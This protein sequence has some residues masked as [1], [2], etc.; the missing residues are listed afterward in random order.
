MCIRDSVRARVDGGVALLEL[1]AVHVVGALVA[2]V[3]GGDDEL[4]PGLLERRDA[5][6]Y[7]R[8]LARCV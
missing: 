6:L 7:L 5:R 1:E 8:Y 4:G 3:E 2:P